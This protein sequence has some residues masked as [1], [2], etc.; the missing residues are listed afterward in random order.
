MGRIEKHFAQ[1]DQIVDTITRTR[2]ITVGP[3]PVLSTAGQTSRQKGEE[4][5]KQNHGR[6]GIDFLLNPFLSAFPLTE[7][8]NA[9]S[10]CTAHTHTHTT[11]IRQALTTPHHFVR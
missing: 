9:F 1:S 8:R 5:D 11:T 7:N 2:I 10:A 6:S 3:W 4:Q